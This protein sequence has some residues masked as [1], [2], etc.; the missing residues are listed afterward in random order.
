MHFE[1]GQQVRELR[2]KTHMHK[3]VQ[4]DR[5]IY[6]QSSLIS[7][8]GERM[9]FLEDMVFL[10]RRPAV[11]SSSCG[12]VCMPASGSLLLSWNRIRA[13]EHGAVPS[14]D[15]TASLSL[16]ERVIGMANDRIECNLYNIKAQIQAAGSRSARLP[17]ETSCPA[18]CR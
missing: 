8:P 16:K 17:T 11:E 12:L 6:M 4:R 13:L 7:V 15:Q 18:A 3:V 10:V 2:I 9:S 5:V 1:H 14:G